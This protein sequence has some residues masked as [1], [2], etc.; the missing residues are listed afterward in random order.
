[1]QL[2]DNVRFAKRLNA[3]DGGGT[4]G[5]GHPTNARWQIGENHVFPEERRPPVP[6]LALGRR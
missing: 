3:A 4:M 2:T 1:M 6:A 5:M